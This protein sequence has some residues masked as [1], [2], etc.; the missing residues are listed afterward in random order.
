MSEFEQTCDFADLTEASNH[1]P[2]SVVTFCR[3]YKNVIFTLGQEGRDCGSGFDRPRG[4][5]NRTCNPGYPSSGTSARNGAM[6]TC[7]TLLA[8]CLMSAIAGCSKSDTVLSPTSPRPVGTPGATQPTIGLDACSL[9]TSPEIEAIQDAPLKD[10]KERSNSNGGLTV[11]QCYFLLPTAADSIVVTVTQRSNDS[12]S[13]DPKETW[14]ELFHGEKKEA[15]EREEGEKEALAPQKIMSLG[16]EAFWA[17]QRFGGALYAL[18]GN[19]YISVSVGGPGDQ[20][21]KIKKSTALAE[22]I[23]KRL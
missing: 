20:A 2:K 11:S 3:H 9:L 5:H 7:L 21:T 14:E 4:F 18:K 12:S 13:R 17:P 8:F 6:R 10:T 22:I 1:F 19:I 16:D 15:S 23:L